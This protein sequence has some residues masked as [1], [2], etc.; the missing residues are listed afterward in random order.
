MVEHIMI[1]FLLDMLQARGSTSGSREVR[2]K[3]HGKRKDKGTD[4]ES[5]MWSSREEDEMSW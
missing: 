5:S 1:V 2:D 3:I 4:S